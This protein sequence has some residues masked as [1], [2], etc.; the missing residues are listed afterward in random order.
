[1]LIILSNKVRHSL[2]S[3]SLFPCC[4]LTFAPNKHLTLF[5]FRCRL[6][7][8]LHQNYSSILSKSLI[9]YY[10]LI[11][12]LIHLK[13][14]KFLVSHVSH[15]NATFYCICSG[16]KKVYSTL[17]L[18]PKYNTALQHSVTYVTKSNYFIYIITYQWLTIL[19][20]CTQKFKQTIFFIIITMNVV[21]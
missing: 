7:F 13:W 19:N 15:S 5:S 17:H 8:L 11:I 14:I 4:L 10:L 6:T 9:I 12:F 21:N 2:S 18:R 20:L 1:M 16:G 3:Y